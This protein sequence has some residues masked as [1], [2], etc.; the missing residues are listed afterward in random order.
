[1]L[2]PCDIAARPA[3]QARS[4]AIAQIFCRRADK[5]RIG[6]FCGKI[7][8][9]VAAAAFFCFSASA[10]YAVANATWAGTIVSAQWNIPLNWKDTGSIFGGVPTDTATFGSGGWSSVNLGDIAGIVLGNTQQIKTMYFTKDAQAFTFNIG[11]LLTSA[12]LIVSGK[13]IVNDSAQQPVLNVG[14]LL[15]KGTLCFTNDATSANAVIRVNSKGRICYMD[16]ANA[17]TSTIEVAEDS[18]LDFSGNSSAGQAQIDLAKGSKAVFGDNATAGSSQINVSDGA[19]LGFQDNSSGGTAAINVGQNGNVGFSGNSSADNAQL[20]VVDGGKVNFGNKTNAGN[21]AIGTSNGGTV[22]FDDGSNAG[23]SDIDVGKDGSANFNDDSSAG[24]SDIDVTNGGKVGFNDNAN[25]GDSTIDVSDGSSVDFNDNS[26]AGNAD[27]NVGKDGSANFNDDSSAGNSDIDVTDGGKVG[28]NDNANGG[29]STIGISDGATVDFGGNSNA[30]SS[31]IVV[32]D[33]GKVGFNDNASAGNSGIISVDNG[34][35]EF[36]DGS[37]ADNADIEV[38]NG[39]KAVFGDN[40]SAGN[41]RII[42]V[43]NGTVDFNDSSNAGNSSVKIG[44]DGTI[45]FN[46]DSSAGSSQIAIGQ[47]GTVSF[48]DN[49]SGGQSDINIDKGGTMDIGGLTNGGMD[50]GSIGGGGTVKLGDNTLTIGGNNKDSNFGGNITG[51]GGVDKVGSGT[52]LLTGDNDYSGNTQVKSGELQLGGNLSNSDVVVNKGATVS[53]SGTVHRLHAQEGSSV[54]PG[55]KKDS[56]DGSAGNSGSTGTLIVEGDT[57]FDKGS[58]L[59]I[60]QGTNGRNDKIIVNGDADIKGGDVATRGFLRPGDVL[61]DIISSTGTLT[62]NFD[63]IVPEYTTDFITPVFE[64]TANGI[65]IR[66]LRNGVTLGAIGRSGNERKLGAGLETLPLTSNLMIHILNSTKAEAQEALKQLSGQIYASTRSAIMQSSNYLPSFMNDRMAAATEECCRT[67]R[68]GRQAGNNNRQEQ[69]LAQI[70]GYPALEAPSAAARKTR[71]AGVL[72][73]GS[74]PV[75]QGSGEVWLRGFSSWQNNTKSSNGAYGHKMSTT[76]SFVGMDTILG[77][78]LLGGALGLGYSAFDN[79]ELPD[80]GHMRTIYS[81]LYGGKQYKGVNIR[82]G[83]QQNWYEI[84][85]RR[86]VEFVRYDD[87][88][89]S[90]YHARLTQ[91]FSEAGLPLAF[92]QNRLEP[93]A[94]LSYNY[95]HNSKVREHGGEAALAGGRGSQDYAASLAGMRSRLQLCDKEGRSAIV[96]AMLGWQHIYGNTVPTTGMS[97]AQSQAFDT[98]GT[99]LERD[100]MTVETG[101]DF[102]ITDKTALGVSYNGQYGQKNTDHGVRI[103]F[104][105]KY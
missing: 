74:I 102:H 2:L 14:G 82:L 58:N 28:F 59:I 15:G 63:G 48:N 16:N 46:D 17:G 53:G 31:D 32:S 11:G 67:N 5:R 37:T 19:T 52:L 38:K 18:E 10:A 3:V 100:N 77:K 99:P 96:H 8:Q 12:T 27:V 21:A 93:F 83:A 43:D 86:A 55:I 1:M 85:T 87:F 66:F 103:N 88:L 79:K 84:H 54:A 97:F 75:G 47:D 90:K 29:N 26:N 45:N 51:S 36:R 6:R 23:N 9:Y 39:G 89:K 61:R 73:S 44:A 65:S 69:R 81:G 22:D 105:G 34:S 24:N 68:R 76:G 41:S 4:S 56:S 42:S 72:P 13:G 71:S 20:N 94:R 49:A 78:W 91:I 40:A 60:K 70:L 80:Y 101:M 7:L 33:G 57:V 104:H 92:S 25:G 62:G 64:R 30:G 50:V 98:Q 35:V 95:L